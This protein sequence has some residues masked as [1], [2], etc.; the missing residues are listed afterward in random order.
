MTVANTVTNY[1]TA[2]VAVVK[3]FVLFLNSQTFLKR[4]VTHIQM[5]A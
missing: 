2:T 3:S 4:N 1:N 5:L